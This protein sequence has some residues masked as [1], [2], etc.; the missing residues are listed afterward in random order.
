MN[1]VKDLES[2]IN[3]LEERNLIK[4]TSKAWETSLTRRILIALFTYLAVSLYFNA[5]GVND[6]WLNAI[7]PTIGFLL[8]TLTLPW[9]KRLWVKYIYK[10]NDK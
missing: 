2:R 1:N 6:P 5:L 8:S 4:D 9:F 3:D 10:N 7:V